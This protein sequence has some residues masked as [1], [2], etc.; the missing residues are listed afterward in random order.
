MA[1]PATNMT[2]SGPSPASAIATARMPGIDVA[3]AL[4]VLGMVLVNYKLMMDAATRGPDW[5]TGLSS[6]I[7][8]R[9]ATLFVMLAGLGIS[10]RSRRVREHREHLRFER[11]SLLKRAAV[12][13]A[14]GL[15]NLHIWEWDILHFYGVYLAFA[16]CLLNVRGAVLWLLAAGCVAMDVVLE[17]YVHSDTETH[18]W[19]FRGMIFNLFAGGV[20]PV[21]PWMA[22]LLIG[23]WIGRQD[24]S[25]RRTRRRIL[26]PACAVIV[27]CTLFHVVVF[28]ALEPFALDA[29]G[30]K[31]LSPVVL[32][33][34]AVCVFSDA[35]IAA[36]VLCLCIAGTQH[37]A[38]RRWVAA[39]VATGQLAFTL[40]I[41]HAI[42]ILIPLQHGL[43]QEGSL[44]LSIAYSLAFYI[45]AVMLCVWWRR[46][47][48]YGPL[49]GLIRQIT[50]RTTPAPWGGERLP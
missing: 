30:D 50:G 46:R 1:T 11:V 10:L 35:A 16:A 43:L 21:F 8:G 26:V 42:A 5:L 47:W 14:A 31:W 29:S 38:E 13:F 20:H 2:P 37:R 33:L 40:Y 7:D 6:M 49:E 27:C 32:L 3:R 39:L 15:L 18:F 28:N 9:A 17:I 34:L 25:Q 22:F 45:V 44:A 4:A 24:L 48:P 36:V 23:M 41:A 19:S 12:L